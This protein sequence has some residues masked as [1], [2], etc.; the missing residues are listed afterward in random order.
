MGALPLFVPG[1]PVKWTAFG[2][3]SGRLACVTWYGRV[4]HVRTINDRWAEKYGALIR[5]TVHWYLVA[6]DDGRHESYQQEQ[7]LSP[8]DVLSELAKESV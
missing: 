7:T 5:E 2:P 6:T 3:L 4:K 1:D 8:F